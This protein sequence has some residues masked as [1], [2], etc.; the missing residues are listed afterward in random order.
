M[1][2][3]IETPFGKL[4]GV[5]NAG[6]DDKQGGK[7]SGYLWLCPVCQVWSG[8]NERKLFGQV[9]IDHTRY[10]NGSPTGC[11]YHETHDFRPYLNPVS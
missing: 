6:A 5:N 9:S 4:C 11:T 8:I 7:M 3:E 10:L 1:S 2:N